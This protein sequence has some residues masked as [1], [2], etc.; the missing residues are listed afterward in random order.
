MKFKILFVF[1]FI[2]INCLSAQIIEKQHTGFIKSYELLNSVKGTWKLVH[3]SADNIEVD[4]ENME[5]SFIEQLNLKKIDSLSLRSKFDIGCAKME[6]YILKITD[7]YI[8][9]SNDTTYFKLNKSLEKDVILTNRNKIKMVK[10]K[11]NYF[12]YISTDILWLE[13][14]K[15]ED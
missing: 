9:N 14:K 6:K 7:K 5:K 4:C 2:Y 8:I 10:L 13:F 11:D 15:I 3:M 12:R 1:T